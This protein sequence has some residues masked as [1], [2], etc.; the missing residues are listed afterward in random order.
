[1]KTIRER[2]RINCEPISEELFTGYFFEVWDKLPRQASDLLDVPRYLQLLALLSFHIFIKERI[3]VAIHETHF[4]GEHN[5][6]NVV[7]NPTVTGITTTGM[8]HVKLLGPSIEIIAW[9]KAGI[10]KLGSPAFSAL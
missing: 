3:N 5:A 10:F 6:T 8:D 1:M 7:Q 2:I 9:H 4:G